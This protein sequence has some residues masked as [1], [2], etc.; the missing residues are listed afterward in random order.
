MIGGR[1][2]GD[3]MSTPPNRF[4]PG[5]HQRKFRGRFR[6][7]SWKLPA[8]RGFTLLELVVVIGIVAVMS[9]AL[10]PFLI[11]PQA[12]ARVNE[13]ISELE[14]LREAIQGNP[15]VGDW[16]YLGNMGDLPIADANG[17]LTPLVE[18]G[19]QPDPGFG[20]LLGSSQ[21][22]GWGGIALGWNGP[23]V[24]KI[25]PSPLLDGWG[26]PYEVV[27]H[28]AP[29]TWKYRL[30]SGGPDKDTS[31]A[32]DNIEF[33]STTTW[34]VS[35]AQVSLHLHYMSSGGHWLTVPDNWLDGTEPNGPVQVRYP[36]GGHH[37]EVGG[38]DPL[39][40]CDAF[41]APANGQC[42]LVDS[43]GTNPERLPFGRHV[44][45]VVLDPATSQCTVGVNCEQFATIDVRQPV[46]QAAVRLPNPAP[47]GIPMSVLGCVPDAAF[48]V[49]SGAS[50]LCTGAT[51]SIQVLVAPNEERVVNLHASGEWRALNTS[52][53]CRLQLEHTQPSAAVV[54]HD[55]TQIL[56]GAGTTLDGEFYSF[57]G[58]FAQL[59]SD[60]GP[61]SFRFLAAADGDGCRVNARSVGGI[62]F[63]QRP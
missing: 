30:R 28:P 24:R 58:S 63:V 53:G 20:G 25:S 14:V 37:C 32:A 16:G 62:A 51:A 8:N 27:R 26:Q 54:V 1:P 18:Q 22:L 19:T 36:K 7:G 52:S 2:D 11:R 34:Y 29:E 3:G 12:Q 6:L 45:R 56:T 47:I 49:A 38:A 59:L 21:E 44:V 9:A 42:L 4:T 5:E 60:D 13:T 48:D 43:T 41:C 35:H 46:V 40:S 15:E 23:Y 57:S 33:P 10:I 17:V 55:L 39:T 61:H 31:T 50:P